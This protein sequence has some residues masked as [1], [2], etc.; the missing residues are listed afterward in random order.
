MKKGR[1]EKMYGS[2]PTLSRADDGNMEVSKAKPGH[3]D[4]TSTHNAGAEKQVA[5]D[6]IPAH[7]R[8]AHERNA[9]H[10]K[11]EMEHATHDHKK[12]GDKKMMHERHAREREEM[13]ARHEDEAPPE[14]EPDQ[15]AEAPAGNP[16]QGV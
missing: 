6:A 13:M 9:M 10:G 1:A 3:P 5:E 2:K 12:H 11:H 14:Q 15:G 16:E 4:K 8:H 7:V